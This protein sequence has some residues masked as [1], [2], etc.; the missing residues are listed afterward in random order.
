MD[1]R[2]DATRYGAAAA[3]LHWGTAA[4]VL[5][6]LPAGFLAARSPDPALS[7]TLLRLHAPLGILVLAST[8]G[9]LAW[10]RFDRRPEPVPGPRWQAVA[11]RATHLLLYGVLVSMG[12]SGVGLMLASGVGPLLFGGEAAPLPRFA[13]FG[14]MAPHALGAV[15]LLILSTLHVGAALFHRFH[16]RDGLLSRMAVRAGRR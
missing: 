7:A 10:W 12:L 4:A 13:D 6:L 3:V 8:V 11:A 14:P 15:A 9:R 5:V 2:G 16:R 1:L